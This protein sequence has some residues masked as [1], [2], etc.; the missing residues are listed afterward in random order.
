MFKN[1]IVRIK[2]NYVVSFLLGDSQA[3]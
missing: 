2:L 3:Y 1:Y